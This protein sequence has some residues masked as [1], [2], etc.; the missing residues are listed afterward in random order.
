MSSSDFKKS[1]LDADHRTAMERQTTTPSFTALL[2][3]IVARRAE[4]TKAASE[5][6]VDL[7][8]EQLLLK[9]EEPYEI[10]KNLYYNLTESSKKSWR[11]KTKEFESLVES[12]ENIANAMPK[13]IVSDKIKVREKALFGPK[14]ETPLSRH[15]FQ[16]SDAFINTLR[17]IGGDNGDGGFAKDYEKYVDKLVYIDDTRKDLITQH[18]AQVK[19][20]EANPSYPGLATEARYIELMTSLKTV[21]N[22]EEEIAS[23]DFSH[24]FADFATLHSS[25]EA[26]TLNKLRANN[27]ITPFYDLIQN[28]CLIGEKMALAAIAERDMIQAIGSSGEGKI[29][30]ANKRL[31]RAVQSIEDALWSSAADKTEI[32]DRLIENQFEA[33]RVRAAAV[34]TSGNNQ[35]DKTINAA[36]KSASAPKPTTS[37]LD[38]GLL[39]SRPGFE[40]L[41]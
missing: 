30:K 7:D 22:L 38:K 36:Y 16:R 3:S 4:M 14:I 32:T 18:T 24:S 12:A 15:A 29:M 35:P 5:S 26:I 6:K 20:L 31:L 13:N 11:E 25:L 27:D 41:R 19:A 2:E 23:K 21:A 33:S 37:E 10:L 34:T 40:G 28:L 1:I 39:G 8:A 9:P 17:A